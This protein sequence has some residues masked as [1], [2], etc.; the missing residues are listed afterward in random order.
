MMTKKKK[1]L[2]DC[3]LIKATKRTSAACNTP[4]RNI[5]G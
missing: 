4:A 2:K 1:T 3:F 5:F